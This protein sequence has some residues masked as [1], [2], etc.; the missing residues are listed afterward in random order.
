MWPIPLFGK[1]FYCRKKAQESQKRALEV[2]AGF[3][4]E[5]IGS[6]DKCLAGGHVGL[7]AWLGF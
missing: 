6:F 1:G 5:R 7:R 2:V 4:G 3:R